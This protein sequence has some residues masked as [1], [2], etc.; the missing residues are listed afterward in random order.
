MSPHALTARISKMG[1]L[2]SVIVPPK[3]VKTPGGATRIPV[4]ASYGGE[5]NHERLL[6]KQQSRGCRLIDVSGKWSGLCSRREGCVGL[7]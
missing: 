4:L 5:T 6:Y 3:I 7:S 2:R 1:I